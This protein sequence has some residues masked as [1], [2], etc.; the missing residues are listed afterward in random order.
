MTDNNT[1]IKDTW[2]DVETLAK[3]KNITKRAVRLSLNQNKYEYKTENIRGG[4]TYKIKLSTI[5]E[6]LQVKYIQEYY[7]EFNSEKTEVIELNNLN[8]KQEK[9]ISEHQKRI[10]LAK[11]DLIINW[12]DFRENYKKDKLKAKSKNIDKEFIELYNTGMLYQEILYI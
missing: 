4:K 1:D 10:A 12:I 6:D 11:Y 2:I 5:E 3:L 9:L 8:I 7:N